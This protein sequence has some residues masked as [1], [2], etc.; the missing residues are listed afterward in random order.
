MEITYGMIKPD[1]VAKK[2]TGDI[3]RIIE[4]SGFEI[5]E[6]KKLTMSKAQA[7][8]FYEVHA[9]R[10][11]FGELVDFI[12]SGPVVAL[13]LRREDAVSQWRTLMGSTNPAQAEKGTLRSLFAESI[14]K[15]AVHG[16]DSVRNAAVELNL[17]FP[18][19][20]S[21]AD[22]VNLQLAVQN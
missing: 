9:S 1:A 12:T 6:M 7:Q 20:A 17:I 3:L 5:V 14:G 15:N 16:S 18:N 22:L 13:A 10:P 4:N 21:I 8:S 11:F 2:Y 19:V